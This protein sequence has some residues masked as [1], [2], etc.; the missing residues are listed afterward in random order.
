MDEQCGSLFR[1]GCT[2][3]TFALKASLQLQ[4]LREQHQKEA[5]LLFINLVKAYDSVNL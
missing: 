3:V 5:H 4:T 2:D 1:K